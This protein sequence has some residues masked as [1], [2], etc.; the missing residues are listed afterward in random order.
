MNEIKSRS[1]SSSWRSLFAVFIVI[2]G[3]IYGHYT[4]PRL[5]HNF[6]QEELS[7]DVTSYY[8]YLPMTFIY[9]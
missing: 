2:A 6:Y 1:A 8:L 7:Y 9:N 3:I 4:L 5:K